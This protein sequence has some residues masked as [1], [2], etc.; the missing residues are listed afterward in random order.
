MQNKIGI[1][2]VLSQ[3]SGLKV[4][5]I[6][7]IQLLMLRMAAMATTMK[8]TIFIQVVRMP[9][10]STNVSNADMMPQIE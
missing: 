10:G 3:K 5:V 2:F 1:I 9:N 8:A 4:I 6:L 7:V